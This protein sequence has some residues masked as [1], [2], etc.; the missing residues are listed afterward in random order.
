M[1]NKDNE[2]KDNIEKF[3]LEKL[4]F[5][6]ISNKDI[7]NN[8]I[9]KTNISKYGYF[10]IFESEYILPFLKSDDIN[11]KKYN[12]FFISGIKVEHIIKWFNINTEISDLL[13]PL[14]KNI[15]IFLIGKIKDLLFTLGFDLYEKQNFFGDTNKILLSKLDLFGLDKEQINFAF[16]QNIFSIGLNWLSK[17]M[18]RHNDKELIPNKN[19]NTIIS[20]ASFNE[21]VNFIYS[22]S[23]KNF[24]TIINQFNEKISDSIKNMQAIE[25]QKKYFKYLFSSIIFLRNNIMH[26]KP[27]Y[28]L[29]FWDVELLNEFLL[30]ELKIYPIKEWNDELKQLRNDKSKNS[31][32]TDEL[33]KKI[34]FAKKDIYNYLIRITENSTYSFETINYLKD[35]KLINKITEEF[36]KLIH[37]TE[38]IQITN[39]RLMHGIKIIELIWNF[40]DNKEKNVYK[41]IKDK[42]IAFL[43]KDIYDCVKN[44]NEFKQIQKYI[45]IKM[46]FLEHLN[47]NIKNKPQK[48]K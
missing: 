5:R 41:K 44:S 12:E 8:E 29:H 2:F 9:L 36:N 30:D 47:F 16:I 48:R 13:S 17:E 34:E 25:N 20:H 3:A 39:M 31:N 27:I 1:N 43:K 38:T 19:I 4:K 10:N 33:N 37:S 28:K 32:K 35:Y 21:L 6:K 42:I 15:E 46:G 40:K 24:I 23:E 22:L 18:K 14:I 11:K 45:E 7:E 26:E